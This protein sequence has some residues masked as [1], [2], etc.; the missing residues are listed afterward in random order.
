MWTPDRHDKHSSRRS[1]VEHAG[2]DVA[3]GTKKNTKSMIRKILTSRRVD[4]GDGEGEATG[5]RSLRTCRRTIEIM[6]EAA[7]QY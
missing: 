4:G 1:I 7:Q 6:T 5:G 3:S 2:D